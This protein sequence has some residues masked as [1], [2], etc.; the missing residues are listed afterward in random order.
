MRYEWIYPV[1][2]HPDEN[3]FV[4]H[5]RDL[6]EVLGVGPSE[7]DAVEEVRRGVLSAVHFRMEKGESLA[8]PKPAPAGAL[9]VSLP[10]PLAA[11]ASVY[12][13]WKRSGLSKVALAE[14]AG[15]A[16]SEIRR[17]LDP[18]KGTKLDLLEQIA[19]ALGGHL[20]VSFVAAE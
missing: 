19:R 16:E 4:G 1:E 15:R 12:A 20:T 5:C 13:A 11:K 3:E 6:P 8:P 14:K 18:G 2:I 7:A 17:A 10:A 9:C